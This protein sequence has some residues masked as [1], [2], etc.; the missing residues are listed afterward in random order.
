MK[1]FIDANSLVDVWREKN[2]DSRHFTW[3]KPNGC[4][5]SRIDFWHTSPEITNLVAES[6]I[7][8]APL[9]DHCV[10]NITLKPH[11]HT[12]WKVYWKFNAELLNNE[13]YVEEVK[14][15]F[16]EIID[17]EI[18]TYCKKMGVSEIQG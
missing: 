12:R 8:T 7:S 4:A 18:D 15:L 11:N 17:N 9:T 13:K 10:I 6:S 16:D 2:A 5:R 14:S 3:I 1:S